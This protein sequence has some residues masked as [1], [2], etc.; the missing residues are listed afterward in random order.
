MTTMIVTLT[1]YH[2]L[3]LSNGDNHVVVTCGFR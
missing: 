1:S 3:A 2:Y